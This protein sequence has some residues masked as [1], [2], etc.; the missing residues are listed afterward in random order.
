MVQL[1]D[2]LK[3]FKIGLAV[4]TQYPRVTDR[5]TDRQTSFDSKYRASALAVG[6]RKERS[7]T[8]KMVIVLHTVVWCCFWNMI[9]SRS[10]L[11]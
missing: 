1:P 8:K 11:L 10:S 9:L 6:L 4:L 3:S 2:G 7:E 5:Q